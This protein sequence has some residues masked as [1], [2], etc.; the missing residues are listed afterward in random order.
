MRAPVTGRVTSGFGKRVHPITKK[1]SFHNG[2]DIAVPVGTEVVAPENGKIVEVWD[3]AKG[4][5]CIAMR[6]TMGT[7]YG[8][9]H[10]SKRIRKVGDIVFEGEVI[11]L[12]GNT[13]ASTGPHVHF[14]VK[15][16]EQWVDPDKYFVF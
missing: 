3:H 16:N 1:E 6:T 11:A 7:R 14:T 13:G 15:K 9:A 5:F 4:G 12:S 2:V 8:F 10:L